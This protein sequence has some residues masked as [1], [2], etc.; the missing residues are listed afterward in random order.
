MPTTGP[1]TRPPRNEKLLRQNLS[2][3]DRIRASRNKRLNDLL[4]EMYLEI[5]GRDG[6][7]GWLDYLA[8]APLETLMQRFAASHR[9]KTSPQNG[10]RTPTKGGATDAPNAMKMVDATPA[11]GHSPGHDDGRGEYD[12]IYSTDVEQALLE[13]KPNASQSR[14]HEIDGELNAIHASRMQHLANDEPFDEFEAEEALRRYRESRGRT[15]RSPDSVMAGS[16]TS[17][18]DDLRNLGGRGFVPPSTQGTP[19]YGNGATPGGGAGLP[20]G[21]TGGTTGSAEGSGEVNHSDDFNPNRIRNG[22][23]GAS[24][25]GSPSSSSS[26]SSDGVS[27]GLAVPDLGDPGDPTPAT[28]DSGGNIAASGE[29]TSSAEAPPLNVPSTEFGDE[30]ESN[31]G[32]LADDGDEPSDRGSLD[33][34]SSLGNEEAAKEAQE[35]QKEKEKK[36]RKKIMRIVLPILIKLL[37][38]FIVLLGVLMLAQCISEL[39]PLKGLFGTASEATNINGVSVGSEAVQT[40][41]GTKTRRNDSSATPKVQLSGGL[42]D[43]FQ[44]ESD[45]EEEGEEE[46]EQDDGELTD[47]Q[48][49]VIEACK[50][51]PTAGAGWCAAWVGD[52]Y[53]NANVGVTFH[54]DARDWWHA[55]CNPSEAPASCEAGTVKTDPNRAKLKPAMVIAVP[56]SSSG[57]SAG[58]TYGH[59]GIYIGNNQVMHNIGPIA[60]CTV[61]EWIATYGQYTDVGWGWADGIK[62]G[63]SGKKSGNTKIN[64]AE[65]KKWAKRIDD[66]LAGSPLA[67]HGKTFAQAAADYGV[68]PRFSPAISCIESSKGEYCFRPHNAWGWGSS[69]WPDWDT[70]IQAHVKGLSEGYEG[71]CTPENAQKYCPPTWQDWYNQVSS[72][73]DRI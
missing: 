15:R 32:V 68:D 39:N 35:A 3:I 41:N 54:G 58:A 30:A 12:Y 31:R 25:G 45:E 72:E 9:K 59:V 61:D 23:G 52:V 14:R 7:E 5:S 44:T 47:A 19:S 16:G 28:S 40:A 46:G 64:S 62:L 69:S 18:A 43:M 71:G 11:S 51:T 24:S 37:P 21:G 50:T 70:A 36:R 34:G 17:S 4:D 29:P 66:Y 67:G 27:A 2:K 56:S 63:G 6:E 26:S 60:T 8:S 13:E 22:N 55:F 20:T 49:R 33:A 10:Q 57:T 65:V 48:R 53:E 1:S 73:M 42:Y 38:I